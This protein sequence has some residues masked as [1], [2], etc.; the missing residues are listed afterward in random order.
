[1]TSDPTPSAAAR[2]A[3]AAIERTIPHREPFLFVDRVVERGE[4]RLVTEWDVRADAP[5]L[6]GHYPGRPIVPGVLICESVFQ[7]GAILCALDA[8]EHAAS[9]VPVL[10]KIGDARFKKP[11]APGETLR[12]DVTLDERVGPARYMTGKVTSAGASVL[13]VEFVVASATTEVA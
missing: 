3:R 10:T 11:V 4:R 1:M 5:F 13:R 12:I 2:D 8:G 7:T 9:G 6:R